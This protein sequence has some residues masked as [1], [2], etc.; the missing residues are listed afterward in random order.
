MLAA[1]QLLT[2]RTA[3]L[4]LSQILAQLSQYRAL[5]DFDCYLALI[6]AKG[7]GQPIEVSPPWARQTL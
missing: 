5:P 4:L 7:E 6:L 2:Q 1:R 3:C